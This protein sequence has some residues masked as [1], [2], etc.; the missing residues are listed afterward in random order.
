LISPPVGLG[1]ADHTRYFGH[2]QPGPVAAQAAGDRLGQ[3]GEKNRNVCRNPQLRRRLPGISPQGEPQGDEPSRRV[4]NAARRSGRDCAGTPNQ[5]GLCHLRR[6]AAVA[7]PPRQAARR[8][9]HVAALPA[10][11]TGLTER[12]RIHRPAADLHS[13]LADPAQRGALHRRW[14]RKPALL[15]N[16]GDTHLMGIDQRAVDGVAAR[17]GGG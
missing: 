12:L 1:A 14:R 16:G 4:A 11:G 6:G 9:G 5:L 17:I 8:P 3:G 7:C 13:H 2:R 10:I 15:G